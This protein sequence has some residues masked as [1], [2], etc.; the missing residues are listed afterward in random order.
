MTNVEYSQKLFDGVSTEQ[1]GVFLRDLKDPVS[2]CEPVFDEFGS[3]I[4]GRL[5][6]WNN[7]YQS[8]RRDVVEV[9][10]LLSGI[11][12]YPELAIAHM[13]AAWF[14]G[15]SLQ[16]LSVAPALNRRYYSASELVG[17]DFW[18]RWQRI[19][20]VVI[21]TTPDLTMY[22]EVQMAHKNQKSL[23]AIAA[24]KRAMAVERERIARGL[25]DTVIQHLYATSLGLSMSLRKAHRE[26]AKAISAAISAIGDVIAE[27]RREIF[28][29]ESR[30][31]SPLRLQLEDALLPIL[32]PTHARM[33]LTIQSTELNDEYNRHIRA[34]CTEATSNA[35]RHGHAREVAIDV[36]LA[37]G[38]LTV[39][40]TD[41]GVGIPADAVN[42]NGLHNLRSRA[43]SLGGHMEITSNAGTGTSIR[44]SIPC[45]GWCA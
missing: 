15:Q 38:E 21:T 29:I 32:L 45:G 26:E 6:W 3:I 14:G 25:H 4:D 12:V 31:S 9:G 8:V 23:L 37:N 30:H 39:T 33:N 35:V 41:D 16:S 40:I 22:R 27:I 2:V 11:C 36:R 13:Q 19:G 5:V 20:D 34:V 44:W 28:D 18:T 17:T 7:A 42:R 10:Q 1:L 24:R 43:E